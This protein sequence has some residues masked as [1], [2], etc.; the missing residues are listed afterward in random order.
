MFNTMKNIYKLFFC[1]LLML[2]ACS[3]TSSAQGLLKKVGRKLG[4]EA[5]K[6][7]DGKSDKNNNSDDN[8][9]QN[10]NMDQNGMNNNPGV[11]SSQV[12]TSST[13]RKKMT[14]PDVK[15]Y[16]AD[17]ETAFGT[18]NYDETRY[19]V[20]QALVGIE[21]EI[22]YQILES[23]PK[24]IDGLDYNDEDDQVLSNGYGFAGFNVERSYYNKK[25]K[26]LDISILNNAALSSGVNMIL[27]NPM[28][29]NNSDNN[30]KAVKVGTYRA[31][32][33]AEEDGSFNLS[34]PIGQS[35]L[36]QFVCRDYQDENEVISSAEK[37]DIAGIKTMLGEQ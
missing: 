26:S 24:S 14:P 34:I 35:S 6:M 4:N 21:L 37:F 36:I 30:Q 5:E 20:Q 9:D 23:L 12:K 10:S 1:I 22:G 16:I 15:K 18:K 33:T 29:M 31:V 25:D 11:S 13:G 17:A 7:L 27:T 19:N 28:Y 32:I 3:Y 8:S 2:M